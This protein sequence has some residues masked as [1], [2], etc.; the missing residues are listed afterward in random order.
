ML[1]TFTARPHR[2]A[3]T[4]SRGN[5]EPA[6]RRSSP[7]LTVG[8]GRCRQQPLP[9]PARSG[10]VMTVRAGLLP[11]R[12]P[13]GTH[14]LG[15]I[16]AALTL[17]AYALCRPARQRDPAAATRHH[18]LT[19]PDRTRPPVS[20]PGHGQGHRRPRPA[21]RHTVRLTGRAPD[22]AAALCPYVRTPRNPQQISGFRPCRLD[23]RPQNEMICVPSPAHPT[24][25]QAARNRR[26][27][28]HLRL[29]VSPA[30]LADCDVL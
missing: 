5:G 21:G 28:T 7:G 8:Y 29:L 6:P 20:S 25:L 30:L 14:L 9:G 1:R 22:I 2:H 13:A 11:G 27:R 16:P 23:Q 17:A 15:Q 3:S 18:H 24:H 4:R 19:R 10:P 26:S 12:L